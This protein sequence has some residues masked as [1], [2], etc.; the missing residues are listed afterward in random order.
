MQNA[1]KMR[2]ERELRFLQAELEDNRSKVYTSEI[3][4]DTMHT[5]LVAVWLWL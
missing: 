5:K 4:S 3:L 2:H 1:L